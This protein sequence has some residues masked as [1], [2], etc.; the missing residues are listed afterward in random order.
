MAVTTEGDTVL[1]RVRGPLQ[2]RERR[3]GGHEEEIEGRMRRRRMGEKAKGRK[4]SEDG[5]AWP[6]AG[7]R[8]RD[9]KN[10]G[11]QS[12]DSSVIGQFIFS[13]H[14]CG[15]IVTYD[16]RSERRTSTVRVRYLRP[17]ISQRPIYC[18]GERLNIRPPGTR[19]GI[20]DTPFVFFY[21]E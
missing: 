20:R 12:Y 18:S 7:T 11:R 17:P 10:R 6:K 1:E 9:I 19:R 3:V 2:R 4:E 21:N 8:H 16:L 15:A 13:R 14:L 5:I